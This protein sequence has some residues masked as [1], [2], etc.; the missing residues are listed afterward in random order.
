MRIAFTF[1]LFQFNL[2]L[3]L[4]LKMWFGVWVTFFFLLL[5]HS[6]KC[7]FF[8]YSVLNPPHGFS[9]PLYINRFGLN[10]DQKLKLKNK[11]YGINK[12]WKMKWNE[13]Y[14]D[15]MQQRARE[16][17]FFVLIC[18]WEVFFSLLHF[19]HAIAAKQNS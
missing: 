17:F 9:M 5:L 3:F 6:M 1:F 7:N 8:F 2:L 18:L 10:I 13:T 15:E 4:S 14:Y 19:P 16:C 12:M 11:W